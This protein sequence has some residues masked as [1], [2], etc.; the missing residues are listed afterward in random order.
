MSYDCRLFPPFFFGAQNAIIQ[1]D[2]LPLLRD[3]AQN[4]FI[5]Y[6]DLNTIKTC[7]Y[8]GPLIEPALESEHFSTW[9]VW[10]MEVQLDE[11]KPSQGPLSILSDPT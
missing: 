11:Q 1:T 10:P 9:E 7:Q 2:Y 5:L 3:P 4:D 6:T 8:F